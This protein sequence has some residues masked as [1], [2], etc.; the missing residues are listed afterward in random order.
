MLTENWP[1]S[2][3]ARCIHTAV[4]C[5][6]YLSSLSYAAVN[7]DAVCL[8]FVLQN[9]DVWRIA[10]GHAAVT[11]IMR[12]TRDVLCNSYQ[13]W[14]TPKSPAR[15]LRLTSAY[16]TQNFFLLPSLKPREINWLWCVVQM[17]WQ[18]AQLVYYE[19]KYR[20]NKTKICAYFVG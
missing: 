9:D 5:V 1:N 7:D 12:D 6:P 14:L 2:R 20:Q 10:C 15:T 8:M 4:N 13:W 18:R 16:A 17:R 11:K 19:L 3:A